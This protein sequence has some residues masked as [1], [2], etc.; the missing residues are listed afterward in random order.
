MRLLAIAATNYRTLQDTSLFFSD[1]YC[2]ISG[3]NNAGKSCVIR[4]LTALF[5]SG[6]SFPWSTD[7]FRLDYKEDKTQ[8]V[9]QPVPI[10]I[11]YDL[12]LTK[13]E[14][15]ALISFIE[16]IASI[17]I[18]GAAT[19]LRISYH[20]SDSEGLSVSVVVDGKE[21]D[22]KAAKEIDKRVKDSNLLFLYNSTTKHEDY[23]YG[24]GRR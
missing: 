10:T 18:E 7:D 16:K 12:H 21:T 22:E 15:P 20:I 11:V 4:L 14:D 1:N 24:R 9:K 13:E 17:T 3:K 6:T 2:T 19:A 8:W 23:Y 5:R